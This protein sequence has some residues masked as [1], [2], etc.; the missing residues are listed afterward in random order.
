MRDS[1]EEQGSLH[2]SI[3]K[4]RKSP[5]AAK[6]R[7]A[8]M[9]RHHAAAS[10]NAVY[11]S[12][13]EERSRSEEAALEDVEEFGR[14]LCVLKE[15]LHDEERITLSF[16]LRRPSHSNLAPWLLWFL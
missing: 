5:R 6:R 14:D 1:R 16:I 11:L 8:L 10:G 15:A 2:A 12:Q 13:K 9:N 4:L 3:P 7:H